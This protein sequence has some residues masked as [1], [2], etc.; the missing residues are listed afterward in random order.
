[1]HIADNNNRL[2]KMEIKCNA[3]TKT[4]LLVLMIFVIKSNALNIRAYDDE[5]EPTKVNGV[6][7]FK[8]TRQCSM[9]GGFCVRESDC[10]PEEKANMPLPADICESASDIVCCYKVIPKPAACH[11]FGGMCMQEGNCKERFRQPLGND[12]DAS[13]ACCILV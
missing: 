7:V 1:V 9:L 3:I 12:C 6:E 11:T 2:L 8:P 13:Q 10:E 4:F 5:D